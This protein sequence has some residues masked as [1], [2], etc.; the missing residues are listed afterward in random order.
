MTETFNETLIQKEGRNS[1]RNFKYSIY[2]NKQRKPKSVG[3]LQFTCLIEI[4]KYQTLVLS[5]QKSTK[6]LL[7]CDRR[8][9]SFGLSFEDKCQYGFVCM[10]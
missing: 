2:Q 7:R 5:L 8:F 6:L 1:T 3:K 9:R 4:S 10:I